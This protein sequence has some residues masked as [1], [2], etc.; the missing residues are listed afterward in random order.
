MLRIFFMQHEYTFFCVLLCS[1]WQLTAT[2]DTEIYR[3]VIPTQ[4]GTNTLNLVAYN[5]A[6]LK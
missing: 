4:E 3:T 2:E 1:Q 6:I 5:N